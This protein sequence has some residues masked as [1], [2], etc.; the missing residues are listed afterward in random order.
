MDVESN[1]ENDLPI[2]VPFD[3]DQFARRTQVAVKLI[4]IADEASSAWS[5]GLYAEALEAL[6]R[7]HAVRTEHAEVVDIR[8]I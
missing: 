8:L 3:V 1:R 7:Y 5:L 4:G 6:Q 2:S